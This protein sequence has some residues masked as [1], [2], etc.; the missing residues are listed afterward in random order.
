VKNW[1][2][3]GRGIGGT[4]ASSLNST[5]IDIERDEAVAVCFRKI[6]GSWGAKTRPAWTFRPEGAKGKN[7]LIETG[8]VA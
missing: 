3:T 8:M 7:E 4:I 6:K 5:S 2:G 1:E